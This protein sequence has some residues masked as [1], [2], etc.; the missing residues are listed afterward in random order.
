MSNFYTY[1]L[2]R[3][4]GTPFYI[5]K[6]QGKRYTRCGGN[7]HAQ[8]IAQKIIDESKKIL[9][10]IIPAETEE[11]AF[12]EEIRLI[13][14]Y[15]RLDLSTGPLCNYTNGGDGSSGLFLSKKVRAT[16]NAKKKGKPLSAEHRTKISKPLQGRSHSIEA[17]AKMKGNTNS[18][19]ARSLETRARI[20]ASM[21]GKIRSL[22]HCANLSKALQSNTNSKGHKYSLEAR[23]KMSASHKAHQ[24]DSFTID[25]LP[26]PKGITDV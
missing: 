13:L 18:C 8:N 23:A 15:G 7:N 11:E 24:L 19:G 26:M 12:R 22:K 9:C 4:D 5:G 21:K 17:I 10:H 3:L 25:T 20:S 2:F 6:G 16:M 1:I 14:L